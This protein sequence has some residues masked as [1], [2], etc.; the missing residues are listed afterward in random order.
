[1][2]LAMTRSSAAAC[3]VAVRLA[4]SGR[5]AQNRITCINAFEGESSADHDVIVAQENE[6]L[7]RTGSWI[8]SVAWHRPPELVVVGEAVALGMPFGALLARRSF[9]SRLN[10]ATSDHHAGQGESRSLWADEPETRAAIERVAATI[11]FVEGQ[12]LLEH[13]NHLANY[14]RARLTAV[15]ASCP[16]I[17]NIEGNGLSM[18]IR[19]VPPLRASQICRSLCERGVLTGVDAA[20]RLAIDPPLAM[21]IAE[22]DVI[23]GALRAAI[24]GLPSI[25][26]S[27]SCAAHREGH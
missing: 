3:D 16:Q 22:I 20:G 24:V 4:R 18:R 13:G 8:S 2:C 19:L 1:V 27:A 5:Q 9:A 11:D 14:L 15:R 10:V 17:E 21:R 26:A 25:T 12:R 23:I 6:T 7:G